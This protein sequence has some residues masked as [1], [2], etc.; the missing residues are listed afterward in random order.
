L[1]TETAK[2][3]PFLS[4]HLKDVGT[5]TWYIRSAYVNEI[6]LAIGAAIDSVVYD[7]ADPQTAL[8]AAQAEAE[9]ALK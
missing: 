1:E 6:S 5:A 3:F 7:N 2:T 9:N 8:D 4:A